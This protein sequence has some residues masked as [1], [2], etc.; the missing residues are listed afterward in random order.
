MLLDVI[1]NNCDNRYQK[2]IKNE[3]TCDNCTYGCFCPSDCKKCL[4][5]IHF[6]QRANPSAPKRN[7]D[8][9]NMADFYTCRYSC[10]YASELVYAFRKLKDIR[11]KELKILSFG[12]GPCTDLFALDFL[13]ESQSLYNHNIEYRGIDY[14]ESIWGQIHRDITNNSNRNF[15]INF[16]YNNICEF[17]DTISAGDWIPDLVTFQYLFSDMNK[18]SG[19]SATKEFINKFSYF[20]NKSMKE[21]SYIVIND[22][23]LA[24]HLEGGRDFFDELFKSLVEVSCQKGRFNNDLSLCTYAYGDQFKDNTNFFTEQLSKLCYYS[25]FDTCASA[26]MIIKKDNVL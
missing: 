17:I 2:H 20:A 13:R 16:Y 19:S 23:N 24:N 21:N 18:H 12:C 4:E 6:P 25:P 26:Q 7:Y 10:R 5:Y 14:N 3:I 22:I 15:K 1:L 11:D 9:P 8:C